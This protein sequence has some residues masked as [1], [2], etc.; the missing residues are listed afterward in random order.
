M[1]AVQISVRLRCDGANT[2]VAAIFERGDCLPSRINQPLDR[3][4]HQDGKRLFIGGQSSVRRTLVVRSL[5]VLVMYAVVILA[6]WMDRDGLRDNLDDQ[7][8]F[9][10]IVY[11]SAVTVTTVGYGDIVPVTRSRPHHRCCTGDTDPI[12]HVA[13]LYRDYLPTGFATTGRGFPDAQTTGQARRIM[14]SSA[15]SAIAGACAANE[16]V[17]RG[18][19]KEQNPDRGYGSRACSSARRSRGFIGIL[20]DASS[21]GNAAGGDVPPRARCLSAQIATTPTC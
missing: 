4:M 10:D 16:L 17:V 20:G 6:F 5:L 15:A 14:S 21:R 12:A 8:S 7:V 2:V 19:D 11:F 1:P 9:I 3:P 13:D 18:V